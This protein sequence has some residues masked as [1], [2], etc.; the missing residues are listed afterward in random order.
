MQAAIA[1]TAAGEIIDSA[2]TAL[3]QLSHKKQLALAAKAGA[4]GEFAGERIYNMAR[5][6][7]MPYTVSSS[8]R[9]KGRHT[10]RRVIIPRGLKRNGTE[11]TPFYDGLYQPGQLISHQLGAG[12]AQ[13]TGMG[14]RIGNRVFIKGLHV[15]AVITNGSVQTLDTGNLRMILTENRQPTKS[16]ENFFFAPETDDNSPIDFGT[17]ADHRRI[18]KPLNR[19]KLRVLSDTRR[20]IASIHHDKPN[21]V[22]ID[23]YFPINRWCNVNNVVAFREKTTPTFDFY[24]FIE[25]N[26]NQP[27]TTPIIFDCQFRTYFSQ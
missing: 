9:R 1:R 20:Q 3:S 11:F 24:M 2:A 8:K 18:V 19:Q 26:D 7:L 12:I 27:F 17:L 4:W 5:K 22:M 23:K 13:G 16:V 10:G 6:S 21:A 15:A 25:R 14:N